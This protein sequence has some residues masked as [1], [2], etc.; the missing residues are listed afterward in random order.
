MNIVKS[1]SVDRIY[2]DVLVKTGSFLP[3]LPHF[4]PKQLVI[5]QRYNSYHYTPRVYRCPH[6]R[7]RKKTSFS[8]GMLAYPEG[9]ML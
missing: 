8:Y 9:N 2:K 7:I 1:D 6:E 3:P 5:C 4:A